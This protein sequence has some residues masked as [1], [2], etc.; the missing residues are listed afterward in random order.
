MI[1]R[2]YLFPY[3]RFSGTDNLEETDKFYR[4]ALGLPLYK[5][6]KFCKIYKINKGSSIR[7]CTRIKKTM[8]KKSLI[9][10]LIVD[11]VDN[12][13]QTLKAKGVSIEDEPKENMKYKIYHFFLEDN[14]GC[15]V[16]IQK[17]L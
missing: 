9:L 4:E 2:L 17:Y 11:D 10:T 14:N 1:K 13:Y 5:N 8:D 7:F 16:E 6:Q 3:F 15:K 12:V